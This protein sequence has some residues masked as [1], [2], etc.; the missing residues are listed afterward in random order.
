MN[1]KTHRV[2]AGYIKQWLFGISQFFLVMLNPCFLIHIKNKTLK[3]V[4]LFPL[5]TN[6][7]AINKMTYC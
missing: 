7:Q 6:A 4:F 3:W 1:D 5:N 2:D